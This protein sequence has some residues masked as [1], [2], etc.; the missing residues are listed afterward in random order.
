MKFKKIEQI[1]VRN[2]I[3]K[4]FSN[5]IDFTDYNLYFGVIDNFFTIL[6]C[7]I[8]VDDFL[9]LDELINSPQ[10]KITYNK[11]DYKSNDLPKLFTNIEKSSNKSLEIISNN[12]YL[13]C[14]VSL[15]FIEWLKVDIKVFTESQHDYNTITLPYINSIIVKNTKWINNLLFNQSEET[16]VLFRN[17]NFVICKDIIWKDSNPNNFYILIIPIKHIKTI[18]DL[19]QKDIPLLNDIQNKAIEIAL[20]FGINKEQLSMFFHYHPSYYQLHLHV[21]I[22]NNLDFNNINNIN[23]RHYFL[24]KVIKKLNKNSNYWN[25]KTLKFE[26]L[27]G[28]KLYK[29]LKHNV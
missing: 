1:N 9:D 10:I 17:S 12:I 2:E 4:Y 21:C 5:I 28:T 13:K 15:D 27:S 29:L 11:K 8:H 6:L 18:R 20:S 3:K 7:I 22:N 14:P 25:K 24:S 19:T 16:I 23:S 26:L